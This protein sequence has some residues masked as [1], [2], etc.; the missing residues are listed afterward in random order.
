MPKLKIHVHRLTD[1][2]LANTH[3]AYLANTKTGYLAKLDWENTIWHRERNLCCFFGIR[4]AGMSLDVS[5]R[6]IQHNHM[7][8]STSCIYQ[9]YYPVQ[10]R[11]D[12]I[13]AYMDGYAVGCRRVIIDRHCPVYQRATILCLILENWRNSDTAVCA[14]RNKLVIGRID[15]SSAN[16]SFVLN[17]AAP[18]NCLQISR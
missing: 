5:G 2:F 17:S 14:T 15:R 7:A 12:D 1:Y 18:Y 8:S 4:A 9:L 11:K 6:A 13:T 3:T 10:S 16:I